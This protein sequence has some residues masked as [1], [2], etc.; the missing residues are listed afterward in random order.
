MHTVAEHKEH[1]QKT[2]ETQI[3]SP[4]MLEMQLA[5]SLLHFLFRDTVQEFLDQGIHIPV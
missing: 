1:I 2:R 5:H 4:G 3:E